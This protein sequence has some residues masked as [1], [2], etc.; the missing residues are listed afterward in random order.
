MA[1]YR[2]GGKDPKYPS[3]AREAHIEGR[4]SLE[5][6]ISDTGNVE[7]LCVILGPAM[8]QKAAFDA[9][10]KWRYK[11]FVQN[12]H[13]VEVKTLISVDFVLH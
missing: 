8:L 4:V 7:D 3:D 12:G 6:T 5:A 1:R 2:I 10:K 13:P 9:V 11:P